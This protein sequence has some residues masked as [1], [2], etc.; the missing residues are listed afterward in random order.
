M[1]PAR[2]PRV[3]LY[4][5]GCKVNQYETRETAAALLRMGYQVVPFGQPV[6]AC[7]VNTCSVTNEADGKSRA[8]LRRARRTGDDPLVVATGCYVDAA[9]DE[10]SGLEGVAAVVPNRDKPRL[11]EILDET[12]RRSGRLLFPLPGEGD[13]PPPGSGDLVPLLMAAEGAM[14]RTRAV[15]KIQ[16]GCNHFCSFC[17][18]P[19]TRGRLRSR[20]PAEVLA[21]ARELA[22][23]GYGEL[24]LTGICLGD[25]GDEKGCERGE[26]DP[27]ALLLE[28]LAGIPGIRRLRMS[29]IDPADAGPDL[30]RTMADLPEVCR[31]LHLSLQAGNDEVLSR[32]RRRYSAAQF[33]DLAARIYDAMPDA[34][35][36]CDVIAGFPGET[37]AQFEETYRLCEEARFCKIHAF[38][39]SPRSG[40][41]A[42]RWTDDVPPGEKQRRVRRLLALSERLGLEF[43]QRYVGDTVTVLAE[44][45]DRHSGQLSGLTGNYLRVAFDGPDSL[46]GQLVRVA[47]QSAGSD[48]G[49]GVLAGSPGRL[50][51]E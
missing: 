35:L 26:R 12:L 14:A 29:S 32:M 21:E 19:F 41:S 44:Q 6:D 9:P 13:A 18:I 2:K 23:L 42:A 5:L 1:E 17:I 11:A 51:G 45:R 40:T 33:R 28:S 3:S 15:I 43:A 24:V 34:G 31:H 4:T 49:A 16:D 7:I 8:A 50:R 27:L 25:Y 47:V 36:T 39:Y 46:R 38:P 20:P 37:D 22:S 30:I 10:V 48:G